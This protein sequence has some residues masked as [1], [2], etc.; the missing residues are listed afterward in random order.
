M[1]TDPAK[2]RARRQVAIEAVEKLLH[3]T[4]DQESV[5]WVNCY[6]EILRALKEER[7]EDAIATECQVR[8]QFPPGGQ[9]E[10]PKWVVSEHLAEDVRKTVARLRT[11]LLYGDERPVLIID[12]ASPDIT[13]KGTR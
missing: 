3:I 1:A 4:S 12:V 13:S 10:H 9:F 8:S 7:D 11:H 2:L 5:T 6:V